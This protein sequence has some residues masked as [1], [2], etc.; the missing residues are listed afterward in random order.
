MPYGGV[1]DSGLPTTP[2]MHYVSRTTHRVGRTALFVSHTMHF[3]SCTA[4]FV[5]RTM[6]GVSNTK[7]FLSVLAFSR[8]KKYYFPKL[9]KIAKIILEQKFYFFSRFS[10]IT[11]VGGCLRQNL[12][13]SRFFFLTPFLTMSLLMFI[14]MYDAMCF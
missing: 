1:S 6:Q 2:H 13:N 7:F 8:G 3:V 14:S 9:L 4:H 12:E 10:A 5:S 11:R